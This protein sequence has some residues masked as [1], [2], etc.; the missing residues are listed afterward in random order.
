[1][2]VSRRTVLKAG[3]TIGASVAALTVL[4]QLA[5]EPIRGVAEAA[6][7]PDIQF[8]IGN[9]IAPALNVDDGGG[10]INVRFGPVY[11]V[12]VTAALRVAPSRNA[13]SVLSQGLNLIEAAYPFSP[14]GVFTFVAYSVQYF[15]LL[16]A[17]LVASAIPRL[18]DGSG[19][20]ALERATPSPTDV[21]SGNGVTKRK[22]NVPLRLESNHVLLTLR[23]DSTTVLN[24]ILN[25]LRGSNVLHGSVVPSIL[26][27][28][29][30]FTSSRLMFQQRGL[31]KKVAQQNGLSFAN[32]VRDTSPMWMSFADQQTSGSAASGNIVTFAGSSHAVLTTARP[33]SYFDNAAVQHLSHNIQDL[34]S[35][36]DTTGAVSGEAG[37]ETYLERVQYM[38]RSNPVPNRGVTDQF[39]NA[40]GP[41][42]LPN[43]FNG[44][45][46]A[47]ANAQAV[48]TEAGEH[49]LGHL[50]ALQRSSRAGDGTPLHIR[51]DGPGF[52]NMDVPDGSRQPKL[53][54]TVFVPTA[55]F[56]ADM[57]TNQASLD[58]QAANNVDPQDNGLERFITATRRQNFLVPP[59][60]HRAFPLA[61]FL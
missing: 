9:F 41:A 30:S 35:W 61:E 57:R 23:S 32:Q 21:V 3:G 13:Q 40:G 31:P 38:F 33:G 45:G 22:F 42:F 37:G 50:S 52:D 46:D 36:Y 34:A 8:D 44:T 53:Q 26:T 11:T 55:K 15:N 59:R 10:A 28:L 56:F 58:L 12:F 14:S 43:A 39:T 6:T 47:A 16:P 60:R 24:D 27:Q 1:M 54:F 17:S 29:F 2:P 25:W 4:E 51:M 18:S 19:R 5:W 7:L 20:F 49:R 48:G